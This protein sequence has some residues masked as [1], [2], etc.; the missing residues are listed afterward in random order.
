MSVTCLCEQVPGDQKVSSAAADPAIVRI[1]S[2]HESSGPHF[3]SLPNAS[4]GSFY[5]ANS[6]Q[7]RPD[8]GGEQDGKVAF[9]AIG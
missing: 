9:F 6:L 8:T 1:A 2:L 5:P 3:T 4:F 7:C